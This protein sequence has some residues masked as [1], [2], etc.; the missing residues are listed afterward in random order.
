MIDFYSIMKTAAE[1]KGFTFVYGRLDNIEQALNLTSKTQKILY[2]LPVTVTLQIRDGIIGFNQYN[3]TV[4][5]CKF[6]DLDNY[7]DAKYTARLKDMAADLEAYIK[8]LTGCS[9]DLTLTSA[10][11]DFEINRFS[12]NLDVVLCDLTFTDE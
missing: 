2:C 3:T 5:L 1:A 8:T 4:G 11:I 7:Y 9:S 12:E 6:G 10:K